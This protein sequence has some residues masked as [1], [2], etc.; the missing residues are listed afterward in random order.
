MHEALVDII[1][2][3]VI[4]ARSHICFLEEVAVQ[5]MRHKHPL[6]DIEFAS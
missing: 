2:S 5:I 4:G 3:E 6:A 1:E